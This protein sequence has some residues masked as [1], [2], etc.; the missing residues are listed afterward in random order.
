MSDNQPHTCHAHGC[1]TPVPPKMFMCRSHWSR[2]PKRT[3]AAIWAE[4]KPGQEGRKDP[5]LRYLAVQQYAIG[6]V[7]FRPDDEEAQR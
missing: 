7:A 1:S 2:L 5:T 6:E 3:Q 4:Y